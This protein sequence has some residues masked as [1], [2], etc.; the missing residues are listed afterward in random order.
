MYSR[1]PSDVSFCPQTE[2]SVVAGVTSGTL[3]VA[4]AVSFEVEPLASTVEGQ[5]D[6]DGR[7]EA[8]H[9]APGL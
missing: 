3:H 6:T 1:R 9:S 8:P 4:T 7:Y 5:R 2:F